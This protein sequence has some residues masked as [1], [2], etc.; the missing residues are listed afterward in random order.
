M[1]GVVLMLALTLVTQM[2]VLPRLAELRT[3]MVSVDSTP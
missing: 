1:I 2:R 3:E